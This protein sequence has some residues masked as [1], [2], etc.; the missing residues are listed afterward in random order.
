MAEALTGWLARAPTHHREAKTSSTLPKNVVHPPFVF[1]WE[2]PFFIMLFMPSIDLR[3]PS[4]ACLGFSTTVPVSSPPQPGMRKTPATTTEKRNP[5]VGNAI[6]LKLIGASACDL[7][8]RTANLRN[9]QNIL[10]VHVCTSWMRR[11]SNTSPAEGVEVAP[12]C[13][14]TNHEWSEVELK[15][16]QQDTNSPR[17]RVSSSQFNISIIP[18]SAATVGDE[19]KP[20]RL[21]PARAPDAVCLDNWLTKY[22]AAP[23]R[24]GE[25][26]RHTDAGDRVRGSRAMRLVQAHRRGQARHEWY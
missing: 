9:R 3:S 26:K 18:Q 4:A 10:C 25:N 2:K 20:S 16:L 22:R 7:K 24:T 5:A 14:T 13:G 17:D 8:P 1:P 15:S 23:L 19:K 21:R 11:A 6:P 12:P